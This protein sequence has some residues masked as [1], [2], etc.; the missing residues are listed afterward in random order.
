PE[1]VVLVG[2]VD[3]NIVVPAFYVPGGQF[4]PWDVTDHNYTLLEGDDYF[5]D[6]L[7]GRLS[8][9]SLFQLQTVISKIINYESNPYIEEWIKSA[10]M[11]GFVN[12]Q[13]GLF[14]HRET[15][16]AVREKL[17]DFEY[18]KV[19]TFIHPYQSGNT[20]LAN[21]INDGHSFVN[22]RGCGSYNHWTGELNYEF[23]NIDDVNNLNN[24]FMLPMVTSMTC[25]GG[26][27][28]A[29]QFP[30]CFGETWLNAGS[31][32]V[33]KGAI[34]FIGPSELDTQTSWNNCID[35]GIYQGITQED[36]F[37]CGEMLLR[38]KMELYNNYPNNHDWVVN[39]SDQFYFY[40]YNLL[41]DPGL[42]I[43]TD[44]LKNIELE[45]CDY[46]EGMNYVSAHINTEEGEKDGFII[47]IT[48]SD[49]LITTGITDGSGNV[50]IPCD[51]DFGSYSVTASKY[52]YIPQTEE[53]S[54]IEGNY[55]GLLDY[56]LSE[57][58]ISGDSLNIELTLKNFGT[59]SAE[60]V[61]INLDTEEDRIEVISSEI[62]TDEIPVGELFICDFQVQVCDEWHN[63]FTSNMFVN[64]SSSFGE[65]SSIIPVEILS[66]E[67][68]LSDFIVENS[69]NCL[70][71]NESSNVTIELKNCGN[72]E[73][74]D[75]N[76]NFISQNDKV[77][78]INAYSSYANIPIN[79]FGNN[80]NNLTVNVA[81]VISGELADFKLEILQNDTVVQEIEF[82]IPIGII[83]EFSP[84]FC[85]YGYY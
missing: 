26:N 66:P 81:N 41:G 60:N 34:A 6:I 76:V 74:N 32:S 37:K 78:I 52:G 80:Q 55:L 29:E 35:L 14:S 19:D 65:N 42:A 9:R 69:S 24:G 5:P 36:L 84:T 33:P 85:D 71:Q 44:T 8:V 63:G 39:H 67:L 56:N 83:D 51:L 64:I 59:L 7:I 27:F 12:L 16:M 75:F 82:N 18:A 23:F 25:G 40:V 22:F 58:P 38:G 72:S 28:A 17:L 49:S 13:L 62:T 61:T 57:D 79:N 21:M 4:S 20:Q 30:S 54:I 70:I 31:P 11:I 10:L 15:K 2:D 53:F 77:E 48:N 3:G 46:Y 1:Y 45:V 73:S 43:W 68:V 50:N 47:A